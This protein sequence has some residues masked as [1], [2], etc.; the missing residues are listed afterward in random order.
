V[1]A[2][3]AGLLMLLCAAAA[4]QPL[5]HQVKAAF[6]F[7]FL[8]FVDWP[9]QSFAGVDAPLAIGVLG[10]DELLAELNGIVQGRSAQ[11]RPVSVRALREG[12]K[13]AGLH[14][15]FVGRAAAAQIPR[16]AVLP[17]VL[18]VSESEGA[19]EQGSMVNFVRVEGRVR[20]EVAPEQA[21]RRGVRISSRMLAVA[22]HVKP[23]RL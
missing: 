21:E 23:G 7:K 13:P 4:A 8:S 12:E 5:E 20:F 3:L 6:V 10:A 18:V 19:L 15:I 11:N 16:L 17:G 9:A 14:L 2:A 1:R 22:Q